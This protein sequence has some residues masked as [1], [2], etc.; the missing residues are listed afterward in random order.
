MLYDIHTIQVKSNKHVHEFLKIRKNYS[1]T[2]W[3][4][5]E[6]KFILWN[7]RDEKIYFIKCEGLWIGLCEI[8]FDNADP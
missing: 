3:T 5:D 4:R 8:L 2:W 6:K 7:V 1:N